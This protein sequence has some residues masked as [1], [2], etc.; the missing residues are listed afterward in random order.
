MDNEA[1]KE[2]MLEYLEANDLKY[3]ER[4]G[5]IS[6]CCVNPE[7]NE[8]SPSAFTVFSDTPFTHCSSC[9]FHLNTEKLYQFLDVGFNPDDLFKSQINSM[10][11]SLDNSSS[12]ERKNIPIYLPIEE[13]EFRKS[14]RGISPE[15][16]E[17]VG[18]FS[19][20]PDTYY[21]R[22]IIIPIY[23]VDNNLR[24]FEAIST[25][26]DI[27]PKVLRPKHILTDDLFGFENLISSDT[28]F[29]T[30]G[31]FSAL[32]F[33]EC[34]YDGIFNFGIGSIKP[35]IKK[36]MLKGVRNV[37]LCGD[38]DTTGKKLNGEMM[39]ALRHNFNVAFFNYP[40]NASD[41]YDANDLLKEYDSVEFKKFVD[42]ML[43][44]NLIK[45]ERK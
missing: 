42:K 24:G 40:F 34:G 2:K 28:V 22:R 33:I 27:Q 29:I 16:F 21:A 3:I 26:K 37:L 11:K 5:K 17:K 39:K 6:H 12:D 13:K 23:D 35:K 36:L 38:K 4:E 20:I 45:I 9:G 25:N 30:E 10:L 31:I 15:T 1:L 43:D 32:S 41:K 18:A 44:K 19:T 14:Y 8:S 7:H